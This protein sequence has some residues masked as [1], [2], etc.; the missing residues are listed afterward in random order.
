VNIVE[1]SIIFSYFF[2][3]GRGLFIYVNNRKFESIFNDS[4]TTLGLPQYFFYTLIALI[5]TGNLF[6]ILNFLFP[7]DVN[8]LIILFSS[9]SLLYLNVGRRVNFNLS[10]F[11]IIGFFS[12]P[13]ILSISSYGSW[14]H[15]DAGLYH[16]GNQAWINNSK[17][18]FGLG[19]L[20][21]WYSWSSIYEYLS[22]FFTFSTNYIFI[23]Y[24]NLLFVTLFFHFFLISVDG[25]ISSLYKNASIFLI[26]YGILDNFGINGGNNGF[27]TLQAIAKADIAFGIILFLL[28]ITMFNSLK[29]MIFKGNELFLVTLIQ[30]FL[31]QLKSTGY[32]LVPFYLFY[33]YKF[34][35]N[36]KKIFK[37]E[38]RKSISLI[39][40]PIVWYVKN[41]IISGCLV[42]PIEI[43]CFGELVWY[44]KYTAQGIS[45]WGR[46]IDRVYKFDENFLEWFNVWFELDHNIQVLPNLI[47]TLLI[48]YM[49]KKIFFY[50]DNHSKKFLFLSYL[51]ILFIAWLSTGAVFRFG[52][53]IWLLLVTFLSLG[54]GNLKTP[55]KKISPSMLTFLLLFCC[56]MFPRMYSYKEVYESRFEYYSVYLNE[57]TYLDKDNSWGVVPLDTEKSLCWAEIECIQNKND[58]IKFS[59]KN[60]YKIFQKIS[61]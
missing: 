45:S 61:Y 53:G 9:L 4:T 6:F 46:S 12:I 43:T 55:I 60:G 57:N 38:L 59:Q 19:N 23:H 28:F 11:S 13:V 41:L 10:K 47:G 29:N 50:K 37:S 24:L 40:I 22:A 30:I 18:V 31:V 2:F 26:I 49:V 17:I 20:N 51:S 7:G 5:Y 16:L 25:K 21:I 3:V 56:L 54:T 42:F 8:R 44:E 1:F 52:Y 33:I 36:E 48:L 35:T 14:L 58:I 32:F 27:I 39:F 34:Y 15:Y